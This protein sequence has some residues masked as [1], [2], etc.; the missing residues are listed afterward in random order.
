MEEDR[1]FHVPFCSCLIDHVH[2]NSVDSH[3]KNVNDGANQSDGYRNRNDSRRLKTSGDAKC[4]AKGTCKPRIVRLRAAREDIRDKRH[5]NGCTNDGALNRVAQDDT[6]QNARHQ[7]L[8]DD[9][10]ASQQ[11]EPR[12]TDEAQVIDDADED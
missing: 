12:G 6:N 4:N 7:R 11:E 8:L 2:K 9:R 1:L 5:L 3:A 10:N